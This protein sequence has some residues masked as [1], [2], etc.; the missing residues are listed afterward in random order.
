M[1]RS[2]TKNMIGVA[3]SAF[4]RAVTLAVQRATDERAPRDERKEERVEILS[5]MTARYVHV[6]RAEFH[7]EP[8]LVAPTLRRI[9][10]F[11]PGLETFDLTW[12]SECQPFLPEVAA[13][14][15]RTVENHV[16]AARFYRRGSG[17]P[18]VV[19]LHGYM[20]GAFRFEQRVWPI[21]WFDRLGM[22]TL[23][24]VLPFHGT[25]ADPRRRGAPEFPGKD[26]RLTNEGFRQAIFDLR[27]LVRYLR[28]AGHSA[29]GLLGMSLGGYTASLAATLEPALD[30]VVPIIPL[31]SLSD[32]VR[33][34]GGLSASAEV[35]AR[36]QSLLDE[37]HR[38]VSPLAAPSLVARER[39]LVIGARADR[40]TP[41]SHARRLASHFG[42]PLFTW[43]GGHLLQFGRGEAF[44]KV[45]EL[46]ASLGII[47]PR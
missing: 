12:R 1:L 47:R 16:A 5:A 2:L 19:I 45:A 20:T 22:D 25:R 8:A 36:E 27:G 10:D 34:Q 7:P 30:F 29:V 9:A 24:F 44:G 13:R 31:A 37:V 18:V 38:L 43:Q 28:G 4:D 23:L 14:Y 46:F 41:V 40:I 35:A 42:A 32:F 39:L 21:A 11:A 26:P 15:S 6:T 3:S 17:R 33:E